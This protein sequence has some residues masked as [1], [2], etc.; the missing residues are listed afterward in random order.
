MKKSTKHILRVI[1]YFLFAAGLLYTLVSIPIS[2]GLLPSAFQAKLKSSGI[3]FSGGYVSIRK[4]LVLL[5]AEYENDQWTMDVNYLHMRINGLKYLFNKQL[6]IRQLKFENAKIH[7]KQPVHKVFQQYLSIEHPQKETPSFQFSWKKARFKNVLFSGKIGV[8]NRLRVQDLYLSNTDRLLIYGT[9]NADPGNKQLDFHITYEYALKRLSIKTNLKFKE[10]DIPFGNVH[11]YNGALSSTLNIENEIAKL[12][13]EGNVEKVTHLDLS[14]NNIRFKNGSAEV[15]VKQFSDPKEYTGSVQL[16]VETFN[17]PGLE[18]SNFKGRLEKEADFTLNLDQGRQSF[19]AKYT[20]ETDLLESTLS[21]SLGPEHYKDFEVCREYQSKWRLPNVNIL[22]LEAGSKLRNASKTRSNSDLVNNG[23]LHI[24]NIFAELDVP[25]I[26]DSVFLTMEQLTM[27]PGLNDF[28]GLTIRLTGSNRVDLFGG[29][30]DYQDKTYSM[31]GSI[32]LK[33]CQELRDCLAFYGKDKLFNSSVFEALKGC[34]AHFRIEK[35]KEASPNLHCMNSFLSLSRDFIPGMLEKGDFYVSI[36]YGGY[37]SN[38]IDIP[39]ILVSLDENYSSKGLLSLKELQSNPDFSGQMSLDLIQLAKIIEIPAPIFDWIPEKINGSLELDLKN[40]TFRCTPVLYGDSWPLEYNFG[41]KVLRLQQDNTQNQIVVDMQNPDAFQVKGSLHYSAL[42]D[43]LS[44]KLNNYTLPYL[45]ENIKT[46]SPEELN[47]TFTTKLTKTFGIQDLRAEISRFSGTLCGQ[48]LKIQETKANYKENQFS[49]TI[50]KIH[51]A[52]STASQ[53]ECKWNQLKKK[54]SIS[55]PDYVHIDFALK[56][57]DLERIYEIPENYWVN[58]KKGDFEGTIVYEDQLLK[59]PYLAFKNARAICPSFPYTD[60]KGEGNAFGDLHHITANATA[61]IKAENQDEIAVETTYEQIY[62]DG[63][64]SLFFT[65]FMDYA[66]IDHIVENLHIERY[67]SD[68]PKEDPSFTMKE[69]KA[70]V[71]TKRTGISSWEWGKSSVLIHFDREKDHFEISGKALDVYGGSATYYGTIE[72]ENFVQDIQA[73]KMNLESYYRNY[74]NTTPNYSGLA[75]WTIHLEEDDGTGSFDIKGLEIVNNRIITEMKKNK[76]LHFLTN[77]FAFNDIQGDFRGEMD[78]GHFYFDS[79]R[80]EN[81]V[82]KLLG[83]GEFNK[84]QEYARLHFAIGFYS[85]IPK[86]IAGYIP[87]MNTISNS[88]TDLIN[89]TF[90][91]LLYLTY[92]NKGGKVR[93]YPNSKIG[94]LFKKEFYFNKNTRQK[95]K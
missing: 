70:K 8:G 28:Y 50:Q 48:K 53:L 29:N 25:K 56:Y 69:I 74:L 39:Q 42:P 34:A 26:Q 9:G 59:L 88:I 1:V 7:F 20:L 85:L 6:Y 46:L 87:G 92:E 82:C 12:Q 89:Q 65:G 90:S 32:D 57:K 51:F 2:L 5:D 91:S 95:T 62:K 17:M 22:T 72:D 68:T 13:L 80:S 45:P 54:D 81:L 18:L 35:K 11:I 21:L 86:K 19:Q 49:T 47:A 4:G 66:S 64:L 79:I 84:P 37:I 36:P 38:Q 27:T 16:L 94:N 61:K 73:E 23:E 24:T 44:K 75:D 55:I 52:E 41:K 77:K 58:F 93:I 63:N 71:V 43:K 67:R 15:P 3:N 60:L 78:Q 33:T 14:Y 30:F 83:Q 76:A 40:K 31:Q 10:I